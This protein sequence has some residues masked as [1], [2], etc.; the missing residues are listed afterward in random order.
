[1]KFTSKQNYQVAEVGD[2]DYLSEGQAVHLAGY[3]GV[4]TNNDRIY[5]FYNLNIVSLLDTPIN[6]GYS[7]LYEGETISGMSGSPLLDD[8]GNLVGIHGIYRVEDPAIRKG[9]SYAIPINTYK[10]LVAE[11]P[12]PT[13]TVAS[14]PSPV[15]TKE[16]TKPTSDSTTVQNKQ[17][18]N[19]IA[20]QET[21]DE[22]NIVKSSET[23]INYT[24]LEELLA[25]ENWQEAHQET[26]DLMIQ[27]GGREE[28]GYLDEE[29]IKN[30]PCQDLNTIDRLWSK[31]GDGKLGF[32]TQRQIWENMGGNT[33]SG[34]D[35]LEK[36]SVKVGWKKENSARDEFLE[37]SE[38]TFNPQI[39]V[40]G[41]L[42]PL[43]FIPS[44]FHA[45]NPGSTVYTPLPQFMYRVRTCSKTSAIPQ[46]DTTENL[47]ASNSIVQEELIEDLNATVN[48]SEIIV[49]L[50]TD[51]LFDFDRSDIREDAISTLKK[52]GQAIS[53][54][55]L[56]M[57]QIAGHTDSKGFEAYNLQLSQK[58]AEAV[59]AWLSNNTDIPR[60][61]L[62]AKGYGETQ[63][64]TENQKPN[65][66]DNPEGR[67]KNRRV[68]VIIPQ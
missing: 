7:V 33:S 47:T 12:E 36:F 27:A 8:N 14:Q 34:N 31:Y 38:L 40:E 53:K 13:D 2:S 25:T 37:Y 19:I 54:L 30:F 42:P 43:T 52:L 21:T 41:H 56:K 18:D 60:E 50:S 57:I 11:Q 10:E 6:Q 59:A 64:V 23:G 22:K 24:R 58:R 68:E 65:G 55:K 20:P 9:S 46:L 62:I 26:R 28:A 48:E 61:N 5:R 15:A 44:I 29:S 17:V 32:N 16:D 4:K 67:A 3:P 39:A 1:M 66:E 45:N 63:P 49:P 35:T 51:V